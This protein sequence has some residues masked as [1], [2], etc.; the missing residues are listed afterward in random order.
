MR[1]FKLQIILVVALI[2]VAAM[3]SCNDDI[4]DNIKEICTH[5]G[6]L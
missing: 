6:L 1:K 5:I 2:G 4:Y 3:Y